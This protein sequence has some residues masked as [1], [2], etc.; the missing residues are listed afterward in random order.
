M[1]SMSSYVWSVESERSSVSAKAPPVGGS[2]SISLFPRVF[3]AVGMGLLFGF[4]FAKSRVV[5]D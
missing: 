2:A 4:S 3:F 1:W 5:R